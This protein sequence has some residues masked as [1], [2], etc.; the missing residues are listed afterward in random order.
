M[1]EK[2]SAIVLAAGKGSRMKSDIQKQFMLLG[3][4]PVVYYSL[5]AFE[6][7]PVDEIL[8]VTGEK[9]IPYCRQEIVERYGFRKVAAVIAGGKE[10]YESVYKGLCSLKDC[11]Y[12][13]VHDGA[14]P[15]VTDRMIRDSL[16]E[17][18]RSRAC[19]VGVPVK[20]TIKIVDEE[21]KGVATP[22]RKTLWQIQTPQTFEYALL[23]HAYDTMLRTGNTHVT[24]DTMIVEQYE[25]ISVKVLEG[26]YFN[27]KITTPEDLKFAEIFLG[28]V[29]DMNV[30]E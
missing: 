26:G 20:D 19:T 10:R 29:V 30:D 15:F 22:D 2:I 28:K 21:M 4:Y 6:N 23:R 11:S 27:L 7:S 13:I 16:S 14:R 24:D 18:K 17:V 9:D 1:K 12:V 3:D 8:L 25:N 5:A